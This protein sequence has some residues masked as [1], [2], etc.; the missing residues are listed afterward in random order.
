M[1]RIHV[2]SFARRNA[3]KLR[4][5][6]VDLIQEAGAFSESLSGDPWLR[7]IISL[8]IPS[9]GGHIGDPVAAFDQ[10]LPKRFPV[11]FPAGETA[12][13]FYYGDAGFLHKKSGSPGA[14][15]KKII[16]FAT[17]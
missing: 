17:Q 16:F 14:G 13:H 8:H 5:E 7:I 11:I 15:D 1:L 3:K 10:Q 2:R 9:I 6:L 12:S 4:I